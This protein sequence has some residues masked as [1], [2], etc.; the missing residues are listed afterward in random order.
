MRL[1][2]LRLID[3]PLARR[4]A[5]VLLAALALSGS[6]C[7]PA[8]AAAISFL[9]P[10]TYDVPGGGGIPRPVDLDGD[11]KLDLVVDSGKGLYLFY[12]K[13]DGTFEPPAVLPMVVGW[14]IA[15][16]A[17]G[18]GRPDLI[19]VQGDAVVVVINQG[20]RQFAA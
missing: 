14:T 2:Y 13:G 17:N 3:L 12:G 9:P 8:H 5:R 1:S 10:V 4:V 18:D 16:D 6:I 20:A 19:A 7:R 11:G 15:A